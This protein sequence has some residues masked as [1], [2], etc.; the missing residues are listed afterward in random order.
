MSHRLYLRYDRRCLRASRRRRRQG[1]IGGGVLKALYVLSVG[2]HG[3][4]AE[5]AIGAVPSV[6]VA[7]SNWGDIMRSD[8][9]MTLTGPYGCVVAAGD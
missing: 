7:E 6:K 9:N 3:L 8:T 2:S 1:G 5:R 4:R